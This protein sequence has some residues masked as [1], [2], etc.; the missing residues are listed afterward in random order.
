MPIH[1]NNHQRLWDA[2]HAKKIRGFYRLQKNPGEIA[3][4]I[5]FPSHEDVKIP[6]DPC[7]PCP[8]E[9]GKAFNACCL[10]GDSVPRVRV[11]T[12]VPKGPLS[13]YAHPKCYLRHTNDCDRKLSKEHYISEAVLKVTKTFGLNGLPWQDPNG[14]VINYGTRSLTSHILCERHNKAVVPPGR[15]GCKNL[16]NYDVDTR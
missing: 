2:S 5:S 1:Q 4:A 12:L 16:R 10:Q 9:S 11:P 15:N 8:C 7:G 3:M 13:G 14:E 6:W